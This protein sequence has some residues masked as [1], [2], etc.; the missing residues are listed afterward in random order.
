MKGPWAG[1]VHIPLGRTHA[2][3]VPTAWRR[4]RHAAIPVMAALAIVGCGGPIQGHAEIGQ[5]DQ[6]LTLGTIAIARADRSL[7]IELDLTRGSARIDVVPADGAVLWTATSDPS[8]ATRAVVV[9][10][11]GDGP[12]RVTLRALEAPA[13]ADYRLVLP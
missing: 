4:L 8:A 6:T 11:A 2:T 10:P 12:W 13:V 7:R 9:L 3:D 1:R 5:V